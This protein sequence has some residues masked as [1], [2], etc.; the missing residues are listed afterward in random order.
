MG[1]SEEPEVILEMAGVDQHFE[2]FSGHRYQFFYFVEEMTE[3][4]HYADNGGC[5]IDAASHDVLGEKPSVVQEQSGR[6]SQ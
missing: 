6:F 2:T 1:V 4:G 5:D 3:E